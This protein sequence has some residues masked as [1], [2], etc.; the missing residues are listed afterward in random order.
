MGMGTVC[1]EFLARDRRKFLADIFLPCSIVLTMGRYD[2][3]HIQVRKTVVIK[4]MCIIPFNNIFEIPRKNIQC[5][6][7]GKYIVQQTRLNRDRYS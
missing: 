4:K 5:S 6:Q 7:S 2:G 1:M 3:E